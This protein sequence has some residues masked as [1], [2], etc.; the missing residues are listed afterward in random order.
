MA[1]TILILKDKN[2]YDIT[3]IAG[4]ISWSDNVDTLGM[5]LDFSVGF[6]SERYFTKFIIECGDIVLL[7]NECEIFRG[8]IINKNYNS[9]FEQSFTAFDFCFYLNKS[10]PIK[11]FNK[12]NA[13]AA[14]KQ[15]CDDSNIE[16]GSIP[17][18]KVSVKHIYY[19]KSVSEI[20]E[21]ILQQEMNETGKK[22]LKEIRENKFYIFERYS[23]IVTGMFKPAINIAEF[24]I[25]NAIS[26]PNRTLSIEEMKNSILIISGGEKSVR[27]LGKAKDDISIS[28]YGL[29]Q[30]VET[31]DEKD[32]SKAKNIAEKKLKELNKVA[33][34]ASIELLGAD[35]IRAGR[36][37]FVKEDYTGLNGD[38]LIKS[39]SHTLSDGMHTMS[40]ELEVVE[41]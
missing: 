3:D 38:Y 15:L 9:M 6:S 8:I 21:D 23:Q 35:N 10:K 1:Y 37:I 19:D 33:E 40:V 25:I 28:K 12:I 20:I 34:T 22:Y 26:N 11:Q 31:I 17:P 29:L 36:V 30:E 13:A 16:I 7:K 41:K 4:N 39:C 2:V 18:M 24:D 32:K 5:Q 27:V 14:I